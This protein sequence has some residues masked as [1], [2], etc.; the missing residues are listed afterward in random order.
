M[1]AKGIGVCA[2]L[3]LEVRAAVYI[4]GGAELLGNMFEAD[5]FGPQASLLIVEFTHL[6]TASASVFG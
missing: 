5:A 3:P 2:E 6:A 1:V 4:G